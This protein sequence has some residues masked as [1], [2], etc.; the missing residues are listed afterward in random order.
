MLPPDVYLALFNQSPIGEYLLSPAEDPVIL[1]VNDTF[2]QAAG[3]TREQLV[4][5]RLFAAFAGDPTDSGDSGVDALRSSL[6]RVLQTRQADALPLQR[7]PISVSQPDGSVVFE[8]RFWHAVSTPIFD[9]AGSLVC[10][11]HR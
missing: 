5:Q 7:Y 3:R 9:P 11:A 1:A 6:A 4:G 2:L 8:E 10:I